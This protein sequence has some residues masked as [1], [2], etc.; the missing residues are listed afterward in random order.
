MTAATLLSKLQALGVHVF[1]D[2]D[3]LGC[4]AGRAP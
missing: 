2:G 4:R 1:L 3:R